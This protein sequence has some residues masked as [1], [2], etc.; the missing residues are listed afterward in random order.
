MLLTGRSEAV[1]VEN[2]VPEQMTASDAM[3]HNDNKNVGHR[4][5]YNIIRINRLYY[6]YR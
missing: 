4:T 5:N 6:I 2:Y 1:L 3:P